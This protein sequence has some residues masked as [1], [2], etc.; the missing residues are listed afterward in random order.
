MSAVSCSS[1]SGGMEEEET[2]V[3]GL[4]SMDSSVV[5]VGWVERSDDP[6]HLGRLPRR[7]W[8]C[9]SLDP[10]Y[11]KNSR[12]FTSASASASTSAFVLYIANEARQVAVTPRRSISGI[13]Q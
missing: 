1:S 2:G 6:T 4:S 12:A 10:T 13:A 5:T 11:A 8:V 7:C 3:V 9:A